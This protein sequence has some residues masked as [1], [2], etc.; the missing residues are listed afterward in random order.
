MGNTLGGR[1]LAAIGL[2]AAFVLAAVPAAAP[3]EFDI[4]EPGVC[5][6][7]VIEQGTTLFTTSLRIRGAEL[8]SGQVPNSL[9]ASDN[10]RNPLL[11]Y[12]FDES[13]SILYN[14]FDTAATALV[15]PSISALRMYSKEL[16]DE[17]SHAE[18][19][20][21]EVNAFGRTPGLQMAIGPAAPASIAS[22]ATVVFQMVIQKP[23]RLGYLHLSPQV[24]GLDVTL[25]EIQA[26]GITNGQI[27]NEMWNNDSF[28]SPGFGHR[29]NTSTIVEVSVLNSTIALIA[30]V[31]PCFSMADAAT[32]A[33]I[34]SRRQ[35]YA[36]NA[37]PSGLEA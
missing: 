22:L 26:D 25:V 14:G 3:A 27:C 2:A 29:V 24:I 16:G 31:C 1:S 23:G 33:Q 35:A 19:M 11:G 28:T 8:I 18:A 30:N 17:Y 12:A 36:R 13:T 37:G 32:P 21:Q 7:F 4:Q 9:F 10:P 20:D 6:S 5:G 34:M 15:R